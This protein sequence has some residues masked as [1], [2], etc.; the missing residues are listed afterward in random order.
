[1]EILMIN[2]YDGNNYYR[3]VLETDRT[4]LAPRGIMNSLRL[5]NEINIWCW[6]GENAN[7]RRRE[8]Y[9]EYKRGR[10]PVDK[11][12]YAGFDLL[13]QI[14][15]HTTAIQIEV[16][17]YEAD[18]VIATLARQYAHQSEVA[19]FSNDYDLLQLSHEFPNRVFVGAQPKTSVPN[20]NIRSYKCLVGDPSD[21]IPGIKG[22]GEK[23]WSDLGPEM[24]EGLLACVMSEHEDNLDN[25]RLTKSTKNWLENKDNVELLR[26][27][28]NVVTL[29][30][31]PMEELTENIVKGD[32]DY[33]KAESI[34][35][36]FL[37]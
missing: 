33:D 4:G 18:D 28:W 20:K 2:I 25:Y 23:A 14:L 30:N 10:K 17:G 13:K 9:P 15:S 26:K 21:N 16:P 11:D 3:K 27:F 24:A 19:I 5:S 1:M 22:F 37:L 29:I 36:E 6:D 34:L 8:W 32:G 31:I 7:Q 12:I 35:K